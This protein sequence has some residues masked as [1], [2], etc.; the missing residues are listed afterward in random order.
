[1]PQLWKLMGA[2]AIAAAIAIVPTAAERQGPPPC[3]TRAAIGRHLAEKHGE[4]PTAGGLALHGSMLEV[5]VSAGGRTWSII[6]TSPE[7][8]SCLVAAG[9]NWRPI[10]AP[11]IGREG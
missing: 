5:F 2:A 10:A 9:E 1:M 8:W 6:F 7:G 11:P 4:L 3:D